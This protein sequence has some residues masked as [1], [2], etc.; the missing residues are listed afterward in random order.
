MTFDVGVNGFAEVGRGLRLRQLW[1]WLSVVAAAIAAVGSAVGLVAADRIYGQE[2]TDLADQSLAQDA[3]NLV[4]VVPLIIVLGL[5]AA[6]GAVRAY[7]CWLGCLAFTAYSYAIY[8]FALHFGPLFLLWIAVLGTS[9]YALVGGLA[10]VDTEAVARRFSGRRLSL[11]GWA[12]IG[13][14]G[15]FALVWLRE[16]VPDLLAGRPSTSAAALHLPAN[17]VHV[18]DLA[19]FLPATVTSGV[20]LLRRSALGY[21]TAP[22][23]LVFL[24]LTCLPVLATPAVELAR[25]QDPSWGVAAPLGVILVATSVVLQRTLRAA[26]NGPDDNS[27]GRGSAS[28]RSPEVPVTPVPSRDRN[29]LP[30][31]GH[32]APRRH[33]PNRPAATPR[34]GRR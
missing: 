23:L 13:F 15:L 4:V 22:G 25:D 14:A 3:V 28:R 1:L 2:T 10:T 24:A 30:A 31:A 33:R 6:R 32:P 34:R 21:A 26:A 7:L 17:P 18:L 20:L 8:A 16:I 5:R 29:A 9:S 27:G 11:T 19:L 12:L